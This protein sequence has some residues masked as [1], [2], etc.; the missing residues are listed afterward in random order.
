[1]N[2]LFL[3]VY[4]YPTMVLFVLCIL[5]KRDGEFKCVKSV[6]VIYANHYFSTAQ[7]LYLSYLQMVFLIK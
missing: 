4:K 5:Y 1:M 3:L 2:Y 7:L 6:S